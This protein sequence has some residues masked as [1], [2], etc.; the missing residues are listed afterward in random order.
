M[1]ILAV[2]PCQDKDDVIASVMHVTIQKGHSTTH[3]KG[4]EICPPFCTCSCCSTARV[5]VA[6]VAGNIF[7]QTF[8]RE[9]PEYGIPAIQDQPINIWQPPQLS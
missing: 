6:K 1:T 5:L 7:S 9:Y 3:E 8:S 2:L 4:K